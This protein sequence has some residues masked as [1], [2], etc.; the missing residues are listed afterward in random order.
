MKPEEIN[1]IIAEY[2]GDNREE[3]FNGCCYETL[4]LYTDSVDACLPVV[5][6]I[7]REENIYLKVFW[8]E[9]NFLAAFHDC[10]GDLVMS[11]EDKSPSLALSTALAEVIN[12]LEEK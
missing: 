1:K 10:D 12:S 5:E 9:M 7:M 3:F 11:F 8:E 2:M 4:K 6:K